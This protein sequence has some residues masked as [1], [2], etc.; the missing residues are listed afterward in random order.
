MR[1]HLSEHMN[2]MLDIVENWT[3]PDP[4]MIVARATTEE[5][6][7][8]SD[9]ADFDRSRSSEDD[10]FHFSLINFEASDSSD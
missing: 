10:H 1:K 3:P 6:I 4:G 5:E 9:V 2:Q 8:D 7:S